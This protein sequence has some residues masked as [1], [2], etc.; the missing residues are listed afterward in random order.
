MKMLCLLAAGAALAVAGSAALA[1]PRSARCAISGGAETPYKGPCRFEAEK[2]GSFTVTPAGRRTFM[3]DVTSVS[4]YLVGSGQ[5]EVRGLTTGG[6]N[7][8][9]GEARRSRRDPACWDGS[10]FRVCVY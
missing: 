10:D 7:S 8:R 4:V 5:A 2:G 1:K 3:G 9:W 6:V